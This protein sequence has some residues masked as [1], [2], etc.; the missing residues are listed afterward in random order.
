MTT[1]TTNRP[2]MRPYFRAMIERHV[3]G[4]PVREVYRPQGVASIVGEVT[5]HTITVTMQDGTVW[6]WKGGQYADR[7]VAGCYSPLMP[8]PID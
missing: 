3:N 4:T 1:P 6:R 2:D 5:S 8:R 7:K